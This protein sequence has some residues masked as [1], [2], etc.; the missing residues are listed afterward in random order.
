M[1]NITVIFLYTL[2]NLKYHSINFKISLKIKLNYLKFNA[3]VN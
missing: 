3:T 1:Q 2:I